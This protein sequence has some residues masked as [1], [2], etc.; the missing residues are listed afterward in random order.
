MYATNRLEKDFDAGHQFYGYFE[1][2]RLL[3]FI[4]FE[5]HHPSQ[6]QMKIHKL[7]V[8]T[9]SSKHGIGKALVECAKQVANTAKLAEIVLNVNRKNPAISFYQK[10][11]FEIDREEVIDIG[12]G[13]IMDD[14]IMKYTLPC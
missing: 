7:Y 10:I 2:E 6:G 1:K 8:D 4:T 3:G 14:Y 9:N 11:N 5:N 12:E 13:F